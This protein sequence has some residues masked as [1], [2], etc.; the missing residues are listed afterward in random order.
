[1]TNHFKDK[2]VAEMGGSV[3][4]CKMVEEEIADEFVTPHLVDKI[5]ANI[6]NDRGAF[7]ARDIPRLLGQAYHDMVTEELWQALKKHKNPKIDF[8]TLN[9]CTIARVKQLQPELFGM[10]A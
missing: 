3:I 6:R 9:H 2:H 4:N 8:K 10:K 1:M 7:N 5:I